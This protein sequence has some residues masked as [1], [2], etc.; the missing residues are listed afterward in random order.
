VSNSFFTYSDELKGLGLAI[1]STEEKLEH[2]KV[3]AEEASAAVGDI[4]TNALKIYT[5]IYSLNIPEI[6][7][8]KLK[9]VAELTASEVS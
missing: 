6:N 9:Q 1:D 4:H 3:L 7:I 8:P 5:D 2:T